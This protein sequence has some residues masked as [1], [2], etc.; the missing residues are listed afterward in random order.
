MTFV[1]FEGPAPFHLPAAQRATAN[2]Q[3]DHVCMTLHVLIDGHDGTQPVDIQMTPGVAQG[4]SVALQRSALEA[5][6]SK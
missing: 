3:G 2:A 6:S 4:L 5:E 1:I